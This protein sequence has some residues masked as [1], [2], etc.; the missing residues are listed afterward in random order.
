MSYEEAALL[1]PF[2][3]GVHAVE[4]SSLKAG[5]SAVIEGPGPIG[6]SIAIAARALGVSPVVVTGLR[7]DSGRLKLA[8]ELGFKTVCAEDKDWIDQVRGIVPSGGADAVFD[9][10]GSLDSV[11]KLIRRGG[12]LVQVGWPARDVASAELRGLFFHGVNLIN[13]RV[14]TPE[15][16]RRTI[17]MVVAKSVNL[18]P[19]VT[20]RYELERGLE[21]FELLRA[22]QGVKALVLPNVS[23]SRIESS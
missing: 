14:R 17:A 2:G 23:H 19:M 16:W 12:E 1:E 7:V 6:L 13:S 15:T 18:M 9:A 10:N 21:A 4:Q 5:D 22:R 3:T 20:H 8:R 11:Q